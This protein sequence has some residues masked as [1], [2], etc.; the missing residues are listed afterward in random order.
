MLADLQIVLVVDVR[1]GLE[2]RQPANA[3]V[4]RNVAERVARLNAVG[5]VGEETPRS[6]EAVTAP[7]ATAPIG[8]VISAGNRAVAVTVA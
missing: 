8:P 3:E 4:E 1:I 2:N 7:R 6:G 5:S